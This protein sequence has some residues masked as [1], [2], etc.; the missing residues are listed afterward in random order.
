MRQTLILFM[1]APMTRGVWRSLQLGKASP[2]LPTAGSNIQI[3]EQ[4]NIT[5]NNQT[6]PSPALLDKGTPVEETSGV[7]STSQTKPDTGPLF[8]Y[9][10]VGDYTDNDK[11]QLVKYKLDKKPINERA[12][13]VKE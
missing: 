1:P 4:G 6:R 13:P 9:C 12:W 2:A 10:A 11:L 8:I 7:A 3:D 5:Y